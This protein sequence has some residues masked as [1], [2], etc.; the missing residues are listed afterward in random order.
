M[1]LLPV[2]NERLGGS[3]GPGY[4]QDASI[5]ARNACRAWL[6]QNYRIT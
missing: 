5:K 2:R 4:T 3:A 1:V 6:E